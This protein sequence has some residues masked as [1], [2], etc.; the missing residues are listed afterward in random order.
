[1]M[2]VVSYSFFGHA[3]K[4]RSS[5]KGDDFLGGFISITSFATPVNSV[6]IDRNGH[7][8]KATCWESKPASL[9]FLMLTFDEHNSL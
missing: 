9:L 2:D 4:P 1:M 7:R 8:A 5:L 6:M 3:P